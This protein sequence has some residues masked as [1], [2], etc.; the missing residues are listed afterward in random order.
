[1]PEESATLL[2]V[3]EVQE[4]TA[5]VCARTA[6]R[7][8]GALGLSTAVGL[9]RRH[10]YEVASK[11]SVSLADGFASAAW[12]NCC[13]DEPFGSTMNSEAGDR[14]KVDLT[15]VLQPDNMSCQDRIRTCTGSAD[16]Y[17]ADDGPSASVATASCGEPRPG[18]GLVCSRTADANV[19][20]DTSDRKID[21]AAGLAHESMAAAAPCGHGSSPRGMISSAIGG[22]MG[23][24]IDSDQVSACPQKSGRRL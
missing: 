18:E 23:L 20:Q 5:N 6:G 22:I 14:S 17:R 8:T 4:K 21:T 13:S 1:M 12:R 16:A 19:N 11:T 2:R 10:Y 3:T 24:M 15:T 7:R 9:A